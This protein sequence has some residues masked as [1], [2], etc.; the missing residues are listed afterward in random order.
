LLL[1]AAC[2][3]PPAKRESTALSDQAD[4]SVVSPARLDDRLLCGVTLS[5][6][7]A[8]WQ[9]YGRLPDGRGGVYGLIQDQTALWV[10]TPR[11]IAQLDRQTLDCTLWEH[12]GTDPDVPL[13]AVQALVRDPQGC[14]WVA[15]VNGVARYCADRGWQPVLLDHMTLELGFDAGG[16]LWTHQ[17]VSRGVRLVTR[18]D[19]HEPPPGQMW[20]GERVSYQDLPADD[21]ASWFSRSHGQSRQAG[22]QSLQECQLLESRRQWL[23]SLALPA[24][25]EAWGGFPP[26]AADQE[27]VWFFAQRSTPTPD[28]P[29]RL[30][31]LRLTDGADAAVQLWPFASPTW[32]IADQVRGGVWVG[33]PEGLI[34]SDGQSVQKML[35][36]P[37]DGMRIMPPVYGLV[38]DK[39]GRVWAN[40]EW[41]LLRFDETNRRWE[42]TE[43]QKATQLTPDDQGGLW[44]LLFSPQGQ[45]SH[46][47]GQRWRHQPLPTN[48]PCNP[49]SIAA[50]VGGGLWLTSLACGLVGFDGQEWASY[51]TDVDLS[52]A[53]LARAPGGELYAGLR[54][55]QIWRYDGTR[56]E[57]LRGTDGQNG[58]NLSALAA[59]DQGGLWAGY[60]FAPH[61]RYFDGSQWHA[62]SDSVAVPVHALLVDS[63]RELWAGGEQAL[64][65]YA[66]GAWESIPTGD[67]IVALAEDR[68]GHIWAN[69]PRGL[70]TYD[71]DGA[72][73][74]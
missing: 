5:E 29:E 38:G 67:L 3:T 23:T 27:G 8:P 13:S 63:R 51:A 54:N 61:L 2:G 40:T 24:G 46:F 37:A 69:G 32:M 56:W 41:G 10:T 42:P 25:L 60:W 48:W 52:D 43:V 7:D 17:P 64:L 6:N 4:V 31:L 70:Y 58:S 65:H 53:L 71:P 15:G 28:Q 39:G 19:G 30:A 26:L 49:R 18:F 59:D 57:L 34:F 21:C 20:Q 14:L 62:F 36:S 74:R 66:A 11:G 73:G 47:D 55:G 35:L 9:L 16:N 44:V 22:F 33:T 72:R 50:D 45:L 12:T 1:V 68:E